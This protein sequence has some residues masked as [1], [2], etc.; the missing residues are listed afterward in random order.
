MREL[1]NIDTATWS[2]DS[3][4]TSSSLIGLKQITYEIPA[5]TYLYLD[6]DISKYTV[7]DLSSSSPAITDVHIN[8]SVR[9]SD[10]AS[11]VTGLFFGF[12]GS[13][14]YIRVDSYS[15]I[16]KTKEFTI[17]SLIVIE[18]AN[19]QVIAESPGR[20]S[21]FYLA[22][23][24]YLSFT[25][26]YKE[27]K[28]V[29][30]PSISL[31]VLHAIGFALD[32]SGVHFGV[33][34]V[35][36]TVTSEDGGGVIDTFVLDN[37]VSP[38]YIGCTPL[39]IDGLVGFLG[40]VQYL[41]FVNAFSTW[42]VSD[43][44]PDTS[45]YF[46]V[47]LTTPSVATSDNAIAC[48]V[49]VNDSLTDPHNLGFQISYNGGTD[50]YV[51]LN[52]TPWTPETGTVQAS[53]TTLNRFLGEYKGVITDLRL[54]VF[55][56]NDGT[57][58][59]SISSIELFYV[60]D[61]NPMALIPKE[62]VTFGTRSEFI[63]IF[64]APT[65]VTWSG[66]STLSAYVNSIT[67]FSLDVS[68]YVY[69]NTSLS[70]LEVLIDGQW[71]DKNDL[72]GTGS[73][74]SAAVIYVKDETNT[75]TASID[76]NSC[77]VTIED[78]AFTGAYGQPTVSVYSTDEWPH[79]VVI[80]SYAEDDTGPVEIS[81]TPG[82]YKFYVVARDGENYVQ[83]RSISENTTIVLQATGMEN[84]KRIFNTNALAVDVNDT[85]FAT[86]DT[87]TLYFQITEKEGGLAKDLTGYSVFFAMK[88]TY[89]S[90][91]IVNRQCTI[92]SNADGKAT[93]QL[94]TSDTADA[95]RFIGEV[96]IEKDG[97]VLTVIPHILLD[98]I[99]S[100]R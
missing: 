11:P 24:L 32:A 33:D 57:S 31:D 94:T 44:Y 21:F 15:G 88:T 60:N 45:P 14:S 74:S 91:L 66:T 70:N 37:L 68:N 63:D 43:L 64:Y 47:A 34:G 82:N 3:F 87:P 53:L 1:F 98:I 92:T 86:G 17:R 78:L 75:V 7:Q 36:T 27:T 80:D 28:T 38:L 61:T 79:P 99:E 73:L 41:S 39:A 83:Y 56:N 6:E 51:P 52:E 97:E 50:W 59:D 72:I 20:F 96:S 48:A 25:N 65:H 55:V 18:G 71:A 81:L 100:L 30:G 4:V 95:G 62:S 93:V 26:I 77:V 54:R 84:S 13:D 9:H 76:V 46:E 29:L 22:G 42:L 12:T 49:K 8:R 19:K 16:Q 23:A 89:T 2:G 35:T 90:S 67:S 85:T 10:T 5:N 58:Q 69:S 40:K